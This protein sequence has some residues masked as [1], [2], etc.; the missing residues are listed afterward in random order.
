MVTLLPGVGRAPHAP[1]ISRPLSGFPPLPA[2]LCLS[3]ELSSVPSWF[4]GLKLPA[5]CPWCAWGS[6]SA[7]SRPIQG[8]LMEL[9]RE[10]QPTTFC[11]IPWVWDRMLDSLKTK[12]LDSTAFRRRIDRWAMRMGLSTNKRRMMGCGRSRTWAQGAEPWGAGQMGPGAAV[13]LCASS[14]ALLL[15]GNPPA[16]VF[17]PGQEIDLRTGQEVPG[18]Q[19]L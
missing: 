5:S 1:S 17:R 4:P 10:V 12:Y 13:K 2:C 14:T 7:P 6:P 16:A 15:K 3:P 11:G 9:L 18:S 8:F 19:P